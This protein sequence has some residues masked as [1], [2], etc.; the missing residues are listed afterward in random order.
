MLFNNVTYISIQLP[1]VLPDIYL[2]QHPIRH[3]RVS[4]SISALL[5]AQNVSFQLAFHKPPS[6]YGDRG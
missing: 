6:G 4:L 3:L 5:P 1:T 2:C